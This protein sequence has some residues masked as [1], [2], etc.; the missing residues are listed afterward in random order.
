MR[1]AAALVWASFAVACQRRCGWWQW[2][3]QQPRCETAGPYK[4]PLP[5]LWRNRPRWWFSSMLNFRI[6]RPQIPSSTVTAM[7]IATFADC[8]SN[9]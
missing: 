4:L 6:H 5:W 9:S 8:E 1:R 3:C 7:R 2:G